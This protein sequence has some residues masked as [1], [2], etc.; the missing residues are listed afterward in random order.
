MNCRVND[1]R[2]LFIFWSFF[3]RELKCLFID[4]F[5]FLLLQLF[6]LEVSQDHESFSTKSKGM[7][8][9]Y[10]SLFDAFMIWE[11]TRD[12]KQSNFQSVCICTVLYHNQKCLCNQHVGVK[13]EQ[14]KTEE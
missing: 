2:S 12:I 11:F 9:I 10:K 5:F 14:K 13:R 3:V 7:A 8:C 1:W 4:F 6:L